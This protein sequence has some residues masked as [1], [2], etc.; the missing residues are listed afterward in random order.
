MLPI[1]S[2]SYFSPADADVHRAEQL[3]D[4]FCSPGGQISV[5][6]GRYDVATGS[7]ARPLERARYADRAVDAGA[8]PTD[9]W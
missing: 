7:R 1:S 9:V 2:I 4:W 8:V 3:L 5:T 6:R